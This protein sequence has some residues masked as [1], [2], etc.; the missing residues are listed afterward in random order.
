MALGTLS[1]VREEAFGALR[2]DV[3][4]SVVFVVL[5]W[6]EAVL[7][8]LHAAVLK[9]VCE[10]AILA[11]VAPISAVITVGAVLNLVFAFHAVSVFLKNEANFTSWA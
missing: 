5:V 4:S 9:V 7:D 11:G 1:H 6:S 3:V 10:P 8:G 2:A